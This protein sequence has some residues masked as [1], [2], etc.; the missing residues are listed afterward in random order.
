MIAP[1]AEHDERIEVMRRRFLADLAA[2]GK[3]ADAYIHDLDAEGEAIAKEQGRPYDWGPQG[4]I[5]DGTFDLDSALKAALSA[6]LDAGYI[7]DRP[8]WPPE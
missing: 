6:L 2:S 3:S 5:L 4:V 7:V 8:F 1:N